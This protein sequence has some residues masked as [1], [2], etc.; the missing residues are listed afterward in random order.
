[1]TPEALCQGE[2]PPALRA[3]LS[4][5][6]DLE[7]AT[8]PRARATALVSRPWLLRG[9]ATSRPALDGHFPSFSAYVPP[10][11]GLT[12]LCPIGT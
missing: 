3:R 11:G 10:Q 5:R 2:H 4:R 7:R 9:I 6:R 12:P 8:V 1:M